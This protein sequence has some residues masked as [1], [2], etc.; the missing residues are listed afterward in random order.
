M[1]LHI[2]TLNNQSAAF[3]LH[4]DVVPEYIKAQ[5]LQFVEILWIRYQGILHLAP[6]DMYFEHYRVQLI[7]VLLV[8]SCV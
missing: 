5:L 6:L 3:D 4:P 2:P 7:L 1:I 8:P